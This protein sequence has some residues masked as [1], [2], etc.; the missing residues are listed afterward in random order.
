QESGSTGA[1]PGSVF[2]SYYSHAGVGVASTT[3]FNSE[4][5]LASGIGGLGTEFD[6]MLG[7]DGLLY[8]FNPNAEMAIP[9]SSLFG[10]VFS[11]ADGAAYYT[12][13]VSDNGSYGYGAIADGSGTKMVFD[14]AGTL[15]GS[16][17]IYREG[18]TALP[19]GTVTI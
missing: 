13:T 2:V 7:T 9:T 12:G 14:G 18:G 15:L 4:H 16:Y 6:R 11:Y 1:A 5:G 17:T 19:S 10:F 3:P 8:A